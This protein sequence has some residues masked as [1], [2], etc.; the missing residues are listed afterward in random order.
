M[1]SFATCQLVQSMILVPQEQALHVTP[2]G[3]AYQPSP[4]S[5]SASQIRLVI[6]KSERHATQCRL[7]CHINV[8]N[9][10]GLCNAAHEPAR[11]LLFAGYAPEKCAKVSQVPKRNLSAS[12]STVQTLACDFKVE[13]LQHS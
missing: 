2:V 10:R 1:C 9:G 8:C 13:H 3:R 12:A 11:A 6:F 7:S 5:A 4:M